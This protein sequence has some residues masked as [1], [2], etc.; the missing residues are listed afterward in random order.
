MSSLIKR[1]IT[2][3]PE[4]HKCHRG[5]AKAS[6][7]RLL[8]DKSFIRLGLDSGY[9][10]CCIA[11]FWLRLVFMDMWAI[12]FGNYGPFYDPKMH[13]KTKRKH[14][15]CWFHKL[16]LKEKDFKYYTCLKCGWIQFKIKKMQ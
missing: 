14:V 1:H 7:K 8:K 10:P 13:K 4:Y 15:T 5:S 12:K 2:Q 11:Y 6:F 3:R 16:I 9:P